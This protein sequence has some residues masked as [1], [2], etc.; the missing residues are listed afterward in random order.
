ML[1]AIAYIRMKPPLA[2]VERFLSVER[3]TSYVWDKLRNSDQSPGP[4]HVFLM[5]DRWAV[6]QLAR[7]V[8]K[9]GDLIEESYE[10]P[11]PYTEALA[12]ELVRV[13]F[14]KDRGF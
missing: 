7:T 6:P 8:R 1:Y 12:R 4:G 13:D 11:S 14:W 3:A 5:C 10:D 2:V 9:Y